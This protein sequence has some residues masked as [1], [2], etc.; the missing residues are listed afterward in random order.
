MLLAKGGAGL[1][2]SIHPARRFRENAPNDCAGADNVL[3]RNLRVNRTRTARDNVREEVTPH[4][5]ARALER[6][7]EARSAG[8]AVSGRQTPR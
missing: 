4:R 6:I 8:G 2:L 5:V 3:P 7:V 1:M